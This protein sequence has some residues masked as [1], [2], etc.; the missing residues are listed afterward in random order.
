MSGAF[1]EKIMWL[2]TLCQA[3][4]NRWGNANGA[5]PPFLLTI[6]A[7][8]GLFETGW[9]PKGEAGAF[10]WRGVPNLRR[11]YSA[12]KG[13]RDGLKWSELSERWLFLQKW[14]H[15]CHFGA[16]TLAGDRKAKRHE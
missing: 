15:I 6:L 2:G 9:L 4:C 11:C 13:L 10:V 3:L 14:H 16:A 7:P 12:E 1:W 8:R 5:G